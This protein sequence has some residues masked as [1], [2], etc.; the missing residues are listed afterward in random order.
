MSG[1][2]EFRTEFFRHTNVVCKLLAIIRSVQHSWEYGLD[3][4]G[5]CLVGLVSCRDVEDTETDFH[6][7]FYR[8]E[9]GCRSVVDRSSTLVRILGVNRHGVDETAC[10]RSFAISS[11]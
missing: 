8:H 10:R 11:V 2:I 3:R 9:H 4:H 5:S 6:Q 1:K 7:H